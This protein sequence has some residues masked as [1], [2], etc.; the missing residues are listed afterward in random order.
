[1]SCRH[2]ACVLELETKVHMKVRNL[3][4]VLCLT[5]VLN[6]IALVG[7]F[8]QEKALVDAFSVIT[9]FHVDL[10]FKL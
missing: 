9:N 1:M 8:N 6:V 7:A 3:L 5:N 10:R 2:V 4:V